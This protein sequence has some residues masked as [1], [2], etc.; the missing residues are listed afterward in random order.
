MQP[1][2]LHL[3]GERVCNGKRIEPAGSQSCRDQNCCAVTCTS[4]AEAWHASRSRWSE[5]WFAGTG[6]TDGL[7][8]ADPCP[9]TI[10]GPAQQILA[11]ESLLRLPG[12]YSVE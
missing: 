7:E 12:H 11:W 10:A 4:N 2:H 1:R 6:A 3:P 8:C 5:W 9:R